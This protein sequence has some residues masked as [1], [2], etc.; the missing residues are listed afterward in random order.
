VRIVFLLTV[1]RMGLWLLPFSELRR[2][3]RSGLPVA[4]FPPTL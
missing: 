2:Q 4:A 3:L 1:V